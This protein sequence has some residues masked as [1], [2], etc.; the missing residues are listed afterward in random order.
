MQRCLFPVPYVKQQPATD[1]CTDTGNNYAQIRPA[2]LLLYPLPPS[3]PLF[4]QGGEGGRGRPG[5]ERLFKRAPDTA[6]PFAS[7][8]HRLYSA[9]SCRRASAAAML[10]LCGPRGW[11][12]ATELPGQRRMAT[13][14][15]SPSC[16]EC[17]QI[18]S[19]SPHRRAHML[20]DTLRDEK[21]FFFLSSCS[22]PIPGQPHSFTG[23][24]CE[25]GRKKE[26]KG[27]SKEK[28]YS[29]L[30]IAK[31]APPHTYARRS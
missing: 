28:Y 24:R 14:G 22:L 12:R 6:I 20:H 5:S 27:G 15:A 21:P 26:K 25:K 7:W 31:A 2:P 13:R 3:T 10:L 29:K 11:R 9:Q 19:V 17:A 23:I 16:Q 30:R 18:R 8:F 4:S 1:T